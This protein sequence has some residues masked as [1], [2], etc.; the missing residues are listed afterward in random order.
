VSGRDRSSSDA[1]PAVLRLDAR[2]DDALSYLHAYVL[3]LD[4]ER[5]RLAARLEA[6]RADAAAPSEVSELEQRHGEL[7]EELDALRTTIDK[8]REYADPNRRYL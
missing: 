6:H 3:A 4:A 2:I 1:D 8:L 5:G 7:T